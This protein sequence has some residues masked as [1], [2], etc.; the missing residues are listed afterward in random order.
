LIAIANFGD[1]R[2]RRTGLA[3]SPSV[4]ALCLMQSVGNANTIAEQPSCAIVR[5]SS[6][7]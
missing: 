6:S 1:R 5:F 2:S 4:T 3:E 7:A